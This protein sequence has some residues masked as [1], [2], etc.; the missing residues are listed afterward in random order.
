VDVAIKAARVSVRI[1]TKAAVEW[2]PVV[3]LTNSYGEH[4]PCPSSSDP[5]NSSPDVADVIQ[6]I[7]TDKIHAGI[8]APEGMISS[9]VYRWNEIFKI[10]NG[11][12]VGYSKSGEDR[13]NAVSCVR[14]VTS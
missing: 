14:L 10:G 1:P 12:V 4:G 13:R 7:T 11:L 3:C 8:S 6:R 9:V 2:V 5:F